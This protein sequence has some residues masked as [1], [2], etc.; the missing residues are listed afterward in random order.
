[1]LGYSH[2]MSGAV[3][4][5]AIAPTATELLG[6][7]P[8]NEYELIAG[9]IATAGAA[10]IPDLDHPQATIAHTFGFVSKAISKVT[11]LLA[12]GHRQGT[13]S[14]IFVAG[15]ALFSYF[16]GLGLN[17]VDSTLPPLIMMFLLASFAFR[18][19]NIVPPKTSSS[20]KGIIV[21]LEAAGL[22]A[23]LHFL[24][25]NSTLSWDWLWLAAGL[26]AFVHLLGDAI[27][28]EGV[29]FFY[30]LRSRFSIPIIA[31]TGNIM[32]RVIISPLLTFALVYLVF[33]TLIVN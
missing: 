4:W 18:G 33:A 23:L 13:H 32:E 31:H 30:P 1:M 11:A 3:A 22:V 14:L 17:L 25:Q 19:L 26:G 6:M 9:T 24:N 7:A 20:F 16:V 29:P 12:G 10:L 21:L 8:L 28:P 2:A 27:T 15:F 5:L